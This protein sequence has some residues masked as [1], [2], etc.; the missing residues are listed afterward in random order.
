MQVGLNFFKTK[1]QK[2]PGSSMNF[3]LANL[4][5]M[6]PIRLTFIVTLQRHNTTFLI[7]PSMRLHS[8]VI[9][10]WL[11]CTVKHPELDKLNES[12]FGFLHRPRFLAQPALSR[13][14]TDYTDSANT[15]N[16]MQLGHQRKSCYCDP[17]T[18]RCRKVSASS[19]HITAGQGG[20]GHP[21]PNTKQ[22]HYGQLC[23]TC[24]VVV[25]RSQ[26]GGQHVLDPVQNPVIGRSERSHD[27]GV[28]NECERW[29]ET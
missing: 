4:N 29:A 8:L 18:M 9:K 1:L 16:F 7:K 19:S 25:H 5:Y 24:R 27:E 10:D 11:K 23:L 2:R 13:K 12:G 20:C 21:P 6:K 26:L 17:W 3:C 22:T 15:I 14:V 28:D